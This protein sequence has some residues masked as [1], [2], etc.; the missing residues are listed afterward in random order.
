[1]KRKAIFLLLLISA[2]VFA[3]ERK[4]IS[5]VDF[6]D[7]YS[8]KLLEDD[9]P[10]NDVEEN[11]ILILYD[12]KTN[13]E[14]F[15]AYAFDTVFQ[16]DDYFS[17]KELNVNVK[18]LPYGEQSVLIFEDFNFDGVEDIAVRTGYFSCYGGPSYDVYLATKKGF[19]K[20][21]S[22][23]ELASSNCGMFAVDY[24]KKQLE[25][26]T[27]S[28]CCWHQFSKYVVEND[29]VVPI[30]ILEEQYMGMLVDYTLF[31]RV[32][33][34]MVKSTYQTFDTENNEPEVTYVFENGKKMHLISGFNHDLY[35]IF[36]NK[37]NRVELTYSDDFQYNTQ[38]NTLLFNVE[39]TTYI[40]S[41]NEILVK[42]GGKEYH[43]NK[44]QSKKGSLKNVNFKEYTNVISK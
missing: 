21:E 28:G 44:I 5:L 4:S 15:S 6:S 40:I 19:K 3:Q 33:G 35:Y 37:E 18:E 32:N 42:T 2:S 24:E 12:K 1:M 34:K 43:L 38:S 20:S 39:K 11:C 30:E 7:K 14:V 8:G 36:T 10:Y 27:K 9:D 22:F 16:S 29:I 31:K 23:S 41:N 26:M 25:T 13:K 17:S